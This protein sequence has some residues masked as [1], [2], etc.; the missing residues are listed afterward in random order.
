MKKTLVFLTVLMLALALLPAVFNPAYSDYQFYNLH[1]YDVDMAYLESALAESVDDKEKA[2]ILWRLS[3]TQLTITDDIKND[4]ENKELRLAEYGKAQD[5]AERAIALNDS[6]NAEHWLSSAIGR[7]GQVN[8]A[9]NSLSKAK[10]MYEIIKKVQ[11][12]F[13]ADMSDSWYVLGILFNQLPGSPISFGNS[14]EAISYMKR[15]LDTQDTVNRSN[16]TNYLETAEQLYQRNWD[17]KKREKEFEKMKSKYKSETLPTE[18]MKYYEGRDGKKTTAYYCSVPLVEISD[19][20]EAITLL[21]YSLAV[22]DMREKQN[23]ILP[24]DTEKK[25]DIEAFLNQISL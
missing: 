17:S 1:A 12:D 11:N 18:K 2:E 9:L 5:Y 19:R 13:N 15:C 24:S 7:I 20:Q 14:K 21:R 3:R 4:K 25:A 6:A 8:G 10:P 23:L 22:Y 16:L